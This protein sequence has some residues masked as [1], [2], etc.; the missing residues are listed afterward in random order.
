[1][2]RFSTS[3]L[4]AIFIGGVIVFGDC[5]AGTGDLSAERFMRSVR[6]VLLRFA[7]PGGASPREVKQ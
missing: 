4:P 3:I 6:S 2:A 1:M 7:R 5:V